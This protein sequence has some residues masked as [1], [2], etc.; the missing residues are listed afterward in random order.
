MVKIILTG[1]VIVPERDRVSVLAELPRHIEL[2][3]QESGCLMFNVEQDRSVP[4]KL[5]VYEE[6]ESMEAFQYH[7]D[8]VRQSEWGKITINVER[9]YNVRSEEDN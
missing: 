5:T 8:R 7:Q 2:T 1:Y 6:F 4:G 9:F 3:R